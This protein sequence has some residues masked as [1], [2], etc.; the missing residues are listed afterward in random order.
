MKKNKIRYFV[1]LSLVLYSCIK[2]DD[3][4]SLNNPDGL[5]IESIFYFGEIKST[6]I[7]ADGISKYQMKIHVHPESTA[8]NRE[9]AL[10]TSLGLFPNGKNTDSIVVD[11]NGEGIIYLNSTI[12]GEAKITA[13]VKTFVIDTTVNFIPSLPHDLLIS[14]DKYQI[15]SSQ[16]IEITTL[17]FRDPFFGEIS[18]P[19]KI[20]YSVISDTIQPSSLIFPAIS[21]SEDNLST[22]T[23]TNPFYLKGD[24]KVEVKTLSSKSDTIRR[25]AHFKID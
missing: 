21:Q 1:L 24:F 20:Y 16:S 19:V 7:E 12:P 6:N 5:K 8:E 17:L 14:L 15:D 4:Y 2:E 23:I 11:A 3:Y 22:V 25:T 10:E 9:I 13:K 18:N